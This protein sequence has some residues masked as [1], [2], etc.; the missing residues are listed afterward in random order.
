LICDI[1]RLAKHRHYAQKPLEVGNRLSHDGTLT[2]ARI[3]VLSQNKTGDADFLASP[4]VILGELLTLAV[5]RLGS[6]ATAAR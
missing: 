2:P 3:A 1:P 4:L 6:I 5:E